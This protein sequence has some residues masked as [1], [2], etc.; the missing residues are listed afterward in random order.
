MATVSVRY[1][2]DDVDGSDWDSIRSR[3]ASRSP[4]TRPELRHA[5]QVTCACW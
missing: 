5:D 2:V 4:C 3:S 1:I